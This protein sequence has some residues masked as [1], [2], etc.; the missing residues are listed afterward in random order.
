L[1]RRNNDD[2]FDQYYGREHDQE[3]PACEAKVQHLSQFPEPLK[4]F[5]LRFSRICHHIAI[6]MPPESLKN[7]LVKIFWNYRRM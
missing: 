7:L 6:G 3:Q 4:G 5:M 2:K 1:V